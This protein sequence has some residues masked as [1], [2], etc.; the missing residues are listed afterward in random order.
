MDQNVRKCLFRFT[1]ANERE[2][3]RNCSLNIQYFHGDWPSGESPGHIPR[4][5]SED[6]K[7]II[8]NIN[9]IS[10]AIYWLFVFFASH[11][12]FVSSIPWHPQFPFFL[13]SSRGLVGQTTDGIPLLPC[14]MV[15][16]HV[17][18]ADNAV[19]AHGTRRRIIQKVVLFFLPSSSSHPTLWLMD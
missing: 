4:T 17:K 8:G 6:K 18:H 15:L 13:R 12:L 9:G 16:C 11:T 14:S 19:A 2:N 1:W 5:R 3:P 7:P 10:T